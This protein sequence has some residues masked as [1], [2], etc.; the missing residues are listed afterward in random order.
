MQS[1]DEITKRTFGEA[2]SPPSVLRV[3]S[4]MANLSASNEA[5]TKP[6][7]PAINKLQSIPSTSKIRNIPSINNGASQPASIN[8]NCNIGNDKVSRKIPSLVVVEPRSNF[9]SMKDKISRALPNNY[10]IKKS[11]NSY[12]ILI[13]TSE[14]YFTAKTILVDNKNKF[15]TCPLP[16]QKTTSLIL[17]SLDASFLPAEIAQD[18]KAQG[19]FIVI[20]VKPFVIA[21]AKTMNVKLDLWLVILKSSFTEQHIIGIEAIQHTLVR[22]E[23]IKNKQVLEF[24]NCQQVGHAAKNCHLSYCCVKCGQLHGSAEG[25]KTWASNNVRGHGGVE[26]T[27]QS[28]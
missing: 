18:L 27:L 28:T 13:K 9:K 4:E 23:R 8:Y 15:F 12:Q 26:I 20:S 3:E 1:Q 24:E 6:P 16:S 7:T 10:V 21:W 2:A 17:R 25:S 14:D 22:I 19:A 5:P 11:S